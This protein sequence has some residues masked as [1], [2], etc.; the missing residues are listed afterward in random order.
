MIRVAQEKCVRYKPGLEVPCRKSE[1]T[2]VM[3]VG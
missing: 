2:S 3:R 1:N